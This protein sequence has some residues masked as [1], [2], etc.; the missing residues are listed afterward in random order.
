MNYYVCSL[1]FE[2]NVLR[3]IFGPETE[4]SRW[5][6]RMNVEL[7]KLHKDALGGWGIHN[8]WMKQETPRKYTQQIYTTN[9]LRGDTK[10]V[11]K[12]M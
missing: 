1:T 6:I 2:R 4:G 11:G 3:K 10:L 8:G 9:D 5:R 7:E 12:M